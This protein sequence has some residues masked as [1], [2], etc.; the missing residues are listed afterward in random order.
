MV[1]NFE[2]TNIYCVRDLSSSSVTIF[3]KNHII[4]IKVLNTEILVVR[5]R[6]ELR[7]VSEIIE[8]P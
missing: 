7:F 1:V 3:A 8:L 5:Y 2:N 6:G 4:I